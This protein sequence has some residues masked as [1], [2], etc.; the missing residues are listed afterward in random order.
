MLKIDWFRVFQKEKGN[1]KSQAPH[2]KQ[3]C[4]SPMI[5]GDSTLS[6]S[7]GLSTAQENMLPLEAVGQ[8]VIFLSQDRK[9]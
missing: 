3:T 2:Q 4:E 6:I 1:W 9:G 5:L 8:M 7:T